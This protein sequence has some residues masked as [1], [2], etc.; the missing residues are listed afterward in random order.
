MSE[1][2]LVWYR[3]LY[4]RIAVVTVAFLALMLVAQSMLFIWASDSWAGSMPA[5][6]P[7]RLAELVASDLSA[8]LDV[9]PSL[10]IR[11]YVADQ[12]TNV[13]QPFVVLMR[14]GREVSN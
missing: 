2:A 9:D 14:D 4:W 7:R 12:Y 5:T 6:N 10:D 1:P 8:A 11:A 13:L 3:S